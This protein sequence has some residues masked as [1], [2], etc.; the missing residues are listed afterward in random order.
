MRRF[1]L[2][3]QP[4]S[5]APPAATVTRAS[6][7]TGSNNPYGR[8]PTSEFA[9]LS[10]DDHAPPPPDYQTALRASVDLSPQARAHTQAPPPPQRTYA[11]PSHPPSPP[12][13]QASRPPPPPPVAVPAPAARS[14]GVTRQRSVEDPLSTLGKYDVRCDA[15]CLGV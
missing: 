4:A 6:T 1:S 9:S 12:A 10:L 2:R 11:P 5:R 13:Q 14:Q 8:Q 15:R 7:T 3:D